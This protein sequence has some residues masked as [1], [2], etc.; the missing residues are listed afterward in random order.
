MK[1]RDAGSCWDKSVVSACAEHFNCVS[2]NVHFFVKPQLLDP[3]DEV[4]T[5]AFTIRKMQTAKPSGL[6]MK[7][8]GAVVHVVL[9]RGINP[10]KIHDSVTAFL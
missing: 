3:D 2:H 7:K 4:E 8:H 5:L 1:S 9:P 6:W 10:C